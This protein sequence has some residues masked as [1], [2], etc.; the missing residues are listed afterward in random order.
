[1][2]GA[3][4]VV[5]RSQI[6]PK[7]SEKNSTSRKSDDQALTKELLTDTESASVKE[8]FTNQ[9]L[10]RHVL[11][12]R[13]NRKYDDTDQESNEDF[14][15]DVSE[16]IP[17]PCRN[18]L[19][20]PLSSVSRNIYSSENVVNE[21]FKP[22]EQS[23]SNI[24]TTLTGRTSNDCSHAAEVVADNENNP[25][26]IRE[27]KRQSENHNDTTT[28]ERTSSDC[29]HAEAVESEKKQAR[30]RKQIRTEWRSKK[31]KILKNSGKAYEG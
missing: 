28:G 10:S 3:D 20:S 4:Q 12:D 16:Y 2:L 30:K 17:S 5:E 21:T 29:L 18:I 22:E 26:L 7:Q 15:P 14:S 6:T 13:T 19:K 23:E 8:T 9:V 31:N 11:R 25:S 1:M 27:I 24:D